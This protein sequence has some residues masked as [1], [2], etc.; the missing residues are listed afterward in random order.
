M[1][2]VDEEDFTYWVPYK[3]PLRAVAF[4]IEDATGVA[5]KTPADNSAVVLFEA[6]AGAGSR[7]EA[8]TL[9]AAIFPS[10]EGIED[11]TGV[12][13]KTPADNSAVVLFETGAGAGSRDDAPTLSAAIL[14]ST[15]VA[16]GV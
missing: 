2:P 1:G 3:A 5:L 13:P 6:G 14:P 15:D 8:P 10:T 4:G 11:A 7:D 16:G 12:F 9:S